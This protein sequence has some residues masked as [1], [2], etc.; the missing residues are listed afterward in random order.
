MSYRIWIVDENE[1]K[2]EIEWQEKQP[3]NAKPFSMDQE[4]YLKLIRKL[5]Y[6][7]IIRDR[8]MSLGIVSVVLIAILAA[9]IYFTSTNFSFI[10]WGSILGFVLA[11][12]I[13]L[14]AI[15]HLIYESCRKGLVY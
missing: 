1:L 15:V 6:W 3:Q 9:V 2:S 11:V 12:Y 8:V 4:K 13:V 7:F 14:Y 5:S 10:T